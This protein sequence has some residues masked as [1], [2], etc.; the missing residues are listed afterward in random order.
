MG[1]GLER[2]IKE[3]GGKERDRMGRLRG[4]REGLEREEG[5]GEGRVREGRG[6]GGGR[7]EGEG[8]W[9]PD[10]FFG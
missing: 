10:V 4:R 2:A 7:R 6:E 5:E 8:E 9:E 1:R 3:L